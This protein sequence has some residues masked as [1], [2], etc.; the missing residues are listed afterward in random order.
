VLPVILSALSQIVRTLQWVNLTFPFFK[1]AYFVLFLFS[2]DCLLPIFHLAFTR[3]R[4]FTRVT[5]S[6]NKKPMLLKGELHQPCD[7]ITQRNTWLM[8]WQWCY[9]LLASNTWQVWPRIVYN[10]FTLNWKLLHKLEK[11]YIFK[12]LKQTHAKRNHIKWDLPV[13]YGI[14]DIKVEWPM[15]LP[16]ALPCFHAWYFVY[17]RFMWKCLLVYYSLEEEDD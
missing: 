9:F 3:W 13:M 5:R 2:T 11:W 10:Q 16:A 17:F 15:L 7:Y 4:R 12:L 1:S 8:T 6:R 14:V